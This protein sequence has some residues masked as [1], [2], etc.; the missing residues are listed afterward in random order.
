LATGTSSGL[1]V[2]PPDPV[3]TEGNLNQILNGLERELA[4]GQGQRRR[5]QA[6]RL[7]RNPQHGAA[8]IID[9]SVPVSMLQAGHR[10]QRKAPSVERMGRIRDRDL[11]GASIP[12]PNRGI[13]KWDRT[14]RGWRTIVFSWA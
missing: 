2:W 12:R 3:L 14:I 5:V 6:C 4:E 8:A 1:R 11:F 7:D 13:K 10:N 9:I